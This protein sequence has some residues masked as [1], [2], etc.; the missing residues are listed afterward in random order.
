MD[1]LSSER[2]ESLRKMSSERL[3]LKLVR[4]GMDED[5][6]IEM[7]R[8]ELLEAV[9]NII[10]QEQ[11]EEAARV[12]LPTDEAGSIVSDPGLEE[13]RHSPG[14]CEKLEV[15]ERRWLREERKAQR[16]AEERRAEREAELR[17]IEAEEKWAE[18][19]ERRAEREAE[20]K[21][22]ERECEE[23]RT[24]RELEERRAERQA[25]LQREVRQMELEQAKLTLE[26][27][28]IE[29]TQEMQKAGMRQR[30][31]RTPPCAHKRGITPWRPVRRGS[32]I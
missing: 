12:P 2:Q 32:G 31:V 9:A 28:K 27:R 21:R 29:V 7:D 5:K 14:V 25:Q 4:C 1:H 24:E 26:I 15:E 3:R 17:R 16:E 22:A 30:R 10:A 20:E 6:V 23:R 13:M 19:E 18:R 8:P 11:L